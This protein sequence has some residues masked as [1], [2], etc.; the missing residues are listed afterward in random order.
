MKKKLFF[1]FALLFVCWF[2][3]VSAQEAPEKADVQLIS[4]AEL[5]E[6]IRKDDGKTR[7]INFWATWCRPCVAEMP[8]FDQVGKAYQDQDLEV[9]FVS[10]DFPDNLETRVAPFVE[11]KKIF[12]KVVLLNEDDAASWMP[13]IDPGWQGNIPATLIVN[14]K[15]GVREFHAKELSR[16]EL[17]ELVQSTF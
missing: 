5:Q 15:R 9:I 10:L 3:P 16:E 12:S 2:S 17:E 1:L 11:R 6:L 7:I 13:A 4:L 14:P 8:H